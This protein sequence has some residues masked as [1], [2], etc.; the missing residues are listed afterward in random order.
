MLQRARLVLLGANMLQE[1]ATL[2]FVALPVVHYIDENMVNHA[3]PF[4]ILHKQVILQ[5]F[6]LFSHFRFFGH[7]VL[8]SSCFG[9]SSKN[10]NRLIMPSLISGRIY[11]FD[12]ET[13]PRAPRIHKV[14][15]K[16]IFSFV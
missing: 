4:S 13:D 11:I 1:L 15:I 12:V 5:L 16:V 6:I 3:F 8:Y 7:F 2:K 14:R 10:R 9:D